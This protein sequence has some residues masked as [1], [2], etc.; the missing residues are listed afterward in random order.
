[1]PYEEEVAVPASI[2]ADVQHYART[3]ERHEHFTRNP[4]QDLNQ[5]AFESARES[6]M[7]NELSVNIGDDFD[8]FQTDYKQL[9]SYVEDRVPY[10]VRDK[11]DLPVRNLRKAIDRHFEDLKDMERKL[12]GPGRQSSFDDF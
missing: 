11:S 6:V 9:K 4:H 2:A 10:S 3:V 1:M 8:G 5:D 12:E 7:D